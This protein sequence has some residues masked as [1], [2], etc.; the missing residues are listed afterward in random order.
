[1]DRQGADFS[2]FTPDE[3]PPQGR[4][5]A[6]NLPIGAEEKLRRDRPGQ[7]EG[8]PG[9]FD[10]GDEVRDMRDRRICAPRP[11]N[12]A[13][14]VR[15]RRRRRRVDAQNREGQA[16]TVEEI[17]KGLRLRTIKTNHADAVRLGVQNK[18]VQAMLTR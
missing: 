18:G 14:M 4:S 5:G 16:L 2:R 15:P 7:D 6:C 8:D 17:K 3:E 13:K 1:M 11:S 12:G 10:A 9:R